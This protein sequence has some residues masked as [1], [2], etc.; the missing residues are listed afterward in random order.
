[1]P[2]QLKY[3]VYDVFTTTPFRGNPL[4]IVHIPASTSLSQTQKQAIAREFNFS[5]TTFVHDDSASQTQSV[6]GVDIFTPY[7]ELPF[8]GHPTIGTGFHLLG[9]H[10]NN[11]ITLRIKAGDTTV[12]RSK[13]AGSV[14]LQV[15]VD[16]KVHP[17]LNLDKIVSYQ[18]HLN[19]TKDFKD[20]QATPIASIVKGMNF[21]LVEINSVDALS[22]MNT[23]PENIVIPSA[24]LGAWSGTQDDTTS[25][26]IH[27]FTLLNDS[28]AD[29]LTTK[30]RA[31]MFGWAGFEDPA[32]GSAAC[33]LGG[34]LG[35]KKGKGRWRFEIAQGLEMGRQSEIVVVAEID[36][37]DIVSSV[38]LE[39]SAVR[40]MEGSLAVDV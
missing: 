20:S 19:P 9:D 10:P 4:A 40:V 8:A 15:P 32:T 27:A 1:M 35:L 29:G 37:G 34:Y 28:S 7:Q 23:Y 18:T 24:H 13:E 21:A 14:H 33:T 30:I 12:T 5:E 6:F 38:Q 3:F 22:R 36:D 17:S 16:F 25:I 39:G 31:R 26:F 11:D 2:S